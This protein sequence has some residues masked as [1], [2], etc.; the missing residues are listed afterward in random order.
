[1]KKSFISGLVAAAGLALGFANPANAVLI[2][3]TSDPNPDISIPD[4]NPTGIT[5]SITITNVGTI[6][7]LEV[8][9]AVTHTF[10]GDLIYT[11]SDGTT[12]VILM[13]QPGIIGLG[14]GDSS[15]LAAT[16]P[17]T[18]SDNDGNGSNS[19]ASAESMGS[20]P[21]GGGDAGSCGPAETIGLSPGCGGTVYIPQQSLSAFTGDPSNAVWTLGIIDNDPGITGSFASWTL[22]IDYT[23]AQVVPEPASLALL[24][25]GLLGLGVVRRR[26]AA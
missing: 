3:Q 25:L 20:N 11:L 26:K 12:T 19:T 10:V 17:I 15:N 22:T 8:T 23:P 18:F 16:T 6:N 14:I 5:N 2:S 7:W 1:M 4:N 21:G 9:V 24:G 13:D